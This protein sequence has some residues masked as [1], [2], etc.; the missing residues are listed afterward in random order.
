ML[1]MVEEDFVPKT[2][3]CAKFGEDRLSSAN[4]SNHPAQYFS[5]QGKLSSPEKL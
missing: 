3:R 4:R 5:F 2:R 1:F